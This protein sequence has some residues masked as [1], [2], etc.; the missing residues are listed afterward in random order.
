M[1]ELARHN[2]P[3][4]C[5]T[6]IEGRVYD[7]T[8]YVDEHPGGYIILD[9]AGKDG[10]KLFTVDFQHFPVAYDDLKKLLIGKLVA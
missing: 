10:T 8:K 5:W 2:Q 3:N 6:A 1:A 4:D 9:A 7:I